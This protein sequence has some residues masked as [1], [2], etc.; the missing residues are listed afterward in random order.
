MAADNGKSVGGYNGSGGTLR[1]SSFWSVG[2]PC[3]TQSNSG[4]VRPGGAPF[5]WPALRH[6]GIC[7]HAHERRKFSRLA[8]RG[9]QEHFG[10]RADRS[11]TMGRVRREPA[12]SARATT[13]TR[14]RTRGWQSAWRIW[15]HQ[16]ILAA[17]ACFICPRRR[18]FI[19]TSSNNWARRVWRSPNARRFVGADYY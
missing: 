5:T 15:K 19:P 18:R 6:R 10:S 13:T 7:A 9:G 17:T 4:H 11:Q 8:G 12:L 14:N 2:R 16:R 1:G 3:Q